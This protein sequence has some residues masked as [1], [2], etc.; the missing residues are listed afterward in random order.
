MVSLGSCH[1]EPKV[2]TPPTP[3]A[4]AKPAV[5]G[6]ALLSN[7]KIVEVVLP[8]GWSNQLAKDD[9]FNLKAANASKDAYLTVQTSAK[10]DF[11]QLSLKEFA[12]IGRKAGIPTMT[13]LNITGPTD[14]T[15]VNGYPAIQY[16]FRGKVDG[17]DAVLLH[18]AIE[19]PNY[20]HQILVGA[21]SDA[22]ERQ[23][24]RFQS[25]IETFQD[26]S[27]TASK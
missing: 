15:T 26:V 1:S 7:Q 5:A 27:A 13:D 22:F 21:S 8:K 16:Q 18:T 25:L 11:P 3:E 20:F 9:S 12:R 23:Q 19:S 10:R 17:I 2:Q 4:S 14:V 6:Q 24:K